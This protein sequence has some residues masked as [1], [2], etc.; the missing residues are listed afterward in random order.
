ME[1]MT[2]ADFH[3]WAEKHDWARFGGENKVEVKTPDGIVTGFQ[4]AYVTP[5]GR[6]NFPIFV[7]DTLHLVAVP[8][9]PPPQ[10]APQRLPSGLNLPGFMSP[11][12]GRG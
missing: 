4:E 6:V 8:M 2:R 3:K 5:A 11:P 12:I 10:P 9:V 1:P 7:N